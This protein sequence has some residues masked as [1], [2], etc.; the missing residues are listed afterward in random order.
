MVWELLARPGM[1]YA[2]EVWWIVG[3]SACRKLESSQMEMDRRLLGARNTGMAVQ[4]DLGWR[5]LEES[6]EEV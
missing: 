6:R 3:L 5:K 2:A 4:G 1:A